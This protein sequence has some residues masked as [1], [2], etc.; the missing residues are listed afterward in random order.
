MRAF[1]RL[2][3][4]VFYRRVE[5]VGAEHLPACGPL[6]VAANHQNAML[7]PMLLLAA[8][9]RPLV[10]VAKAPLFRH[11]L[12]GPFVRLAGAIP[13]HRRVDAG[14][15]PAANAEM[16]RHAVAG[17]AAG[18]ALLIFPEG[19]SQPQPM[20]MPL[21]S[22]AARMLLAAEAAHVG[23]GVRLV[24]AGLV[25]HEP[26]RFRAGRA[27]VVFGDPVDTTEFVRLYA[28][29]APEAA[30]RLTEHLA[31]RLRALIVDA[32]DRETLRLL[33]LLEAMGRAESTPASDEAGRA[34]WMRQAM[35][36]YRWLRA[37]DP[38]R[39]A[40]FRRR[41]ERY[42]KMLEATG[43][44]PDRPVP[45][46]STA[47]AWRQAA[48]EAVALLLGLPLA[49]IGIALH[50]V[51]YGLTR[52]AVS[53]LPHEPDE[54]A[55]YGV[56]AAVVFYPLCWALEAWLAWRLG[57]GPA[58]AAL[59]AAL[60]PSGFFALGWRDRLESLRSDARVLLRLVRDPRLG[61]RLGTQRR[62][63]LD[64]MTALARSVPGDVLA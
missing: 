6:I 59:L 8:A 4:G 62:A 28:R 39:V 5:V 35:R 1:C 24:P 2:V 13:V 29:D 15:D 41:V 27:L 11:P 12:I 10:P 52:V 16:F 63:L 54:E 51:P 3:V 14:A 49:A 32:D 44:A 50:G 18:R 25:Y 37:H 47:A 21:R 26:G 36:A 7:D 60:L 53:A 56:A 23:L 9:G 40:G 58:L 46:S 34:A 57:G 33:D 17:L 45:V 64:E 61:P 38:A 42:A 43:L 48:G 55:T 19:A 22:G 30:R 20:L 31:G